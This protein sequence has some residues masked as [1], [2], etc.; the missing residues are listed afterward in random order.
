M[1]QRGKKATSQVLA[2]LSYQQNKKNQELSSVICDVCK[3]PFVYTKDTWKE[4]QTPKEMLMEWYRT[5][6]SAGVVP[7]FK[8]KA[9]KDGQVGYQSEVV[10]THVQSESG[11]G[12]KILSS[13]FPVQSS[14]L[15]DQGVALLAI[16]FIH[17]SKYNKSLKVQQQ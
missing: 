2:G 16:H 7:V 11:N 5:H 8:A 14:K 4:T 9:N 17:N 10:L 12:E 1:H 6:F 3:L 15:A 13:R